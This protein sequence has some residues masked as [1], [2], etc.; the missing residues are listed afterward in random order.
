M[1]DIGLL[2]TAGCCQVIRTKAVYPFYMLLLFVDVI[3]DTVEVAQ[4]SQD[5]NETTTLVT[6]LIYT[7]DACVAS[8]WIIFLVE[9]YITYITN[10]LTI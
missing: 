2:V 8:A 9:I 7:W 4:F 3:T 1:E 5:K 10:L 6:N